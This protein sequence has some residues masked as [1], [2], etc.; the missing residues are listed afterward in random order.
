MSK[1]T[2]EGKQLFFQRLGQ[3]VPLI[4]IHGSLC[5]H[6]L[7]DLQQSLTKRAQLVLLDLPGHGDSEPLDGSISVSRFS[8]I[9]AKLMH[10]LKLR[11]VVPV[12]HSLGGA[13]AIQL[14]LDYPQLLSGLVLIGTGAK[15]GVLPA[16]LEGLRTQYKAGIELTIG[17]LGF[18][19]HA[20]PKL[21]EWSKAECLYCDPSIGYADF[22]ACNEFDVRNRI[23][24]IKVPTLVL[25]G[26]EDQLTPI[27][28]AHFLADKIPKAKLTI[29]Q[30][31]GHM[32]MLE[33]PENV[34]AAISSFLKDLSENTHQY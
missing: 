13:I 21:V 26:E 10:R 34:N 17:Q 25:F 32:V 16:I 18:A 27:K 14:A 11:S 8:R 2:I 15:L 29:I 30:Q 23:H 6:R 24:E 28:W 7:W 22:V 19:P 1:I 33:Q 3:G 12:G 31:A 5:R 20:D 9:I 4:M